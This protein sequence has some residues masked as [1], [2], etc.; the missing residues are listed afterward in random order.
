MQKLLFLS[1]ER[2]DQL[3]RILLPLLNCDKVA[4][5]CFINT[6]NCGS[7][8]ST[9]SPALFQ[10]EKNTDSHQSSQYQNSFAPFPGIF[11]PLLDFHGIGGYRTNRS[12]G[13]S[14]LGSGQSF[15]LVENAPDV[16]DLLVHYC[17]KW[18][19]DRCMTLDE[20]PWGLLLWCK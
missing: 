2:K 7:R 8:I 16:T 5:T 20:V 4:K 15:K 3:S 13:S 1:L 14:R 9:S 11:C 10:W 18:D 6:L 19:K 17:R 12:L